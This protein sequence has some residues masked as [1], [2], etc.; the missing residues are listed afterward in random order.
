MTQGHMIAAT[1]VI[2]TTVEVDARG[3]MTI[4][5]VVVVA[6]VAA[7]EGT[8]TGT[9]IMIAT[10]VTAIVSGAT[11]EIGMMTGGI[12]NLVATHIRWNKHLLLKT[13]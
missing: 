4:A 9:E 7:A 10:V 6:V 11:A 2:T 12:S 1:P 5:V 8:T 3:V 13:T